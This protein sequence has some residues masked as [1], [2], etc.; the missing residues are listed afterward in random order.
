MLLMSRIVT[1]LRSRRLAVWLLLACV[2]WAAL[3]SAVPQYALDGKEQVV[4]W[5]ADHPLAAVP[6]GLLGLHAAWTAPVF[7]LA[8][9]VLAASTGACAF[10]RTRWAR[11]A[12]R[13][14]ARLSEARR[15]E[16]REH[17]SVNVDAGDRDVP[18]AL[19]AAETVLR[20][21][22]YRVEDS[23]ADAIAAIK[24]RYGPLG[25]SLFH[26]SLTALFVVVALG[27]L[28]RSEGLIGVPVGGQVPNRADQYGLLERG[29]LYPDR[30]AGLLVA[31]PDMA[32]GQVR[33]GVKIGSVP[34]VQ[35]ISGGAVVADQD[36]YANNPLRYGSLMIHLA[37]EGLVAFVDITAPDGT[38]LPSKRAYFDPDSS[39]PS[40]FAQSRLAYVGPDGRFDVVLEPSPRASE[41]EAPKVEVTVAGPGAASMTTVTILGTQL[42]T[43]VGTLVVRDPGAY[44][45]LSVVDDA[46]VYPIYALFLVGLAGLGLAI[47]KPRHRVW[48]SADSASEGRTRLS[49]V[50]DGGTRDTALLIELEDEL[51]AE[52]GHP[53]NAKE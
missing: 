36:V 24:G 52:L 42:D 7:L 18:G 53:V 12:V 37:G 11:V 49:V 44:A 22:G 43:P 48:V 35:L 25:S 28:T 31:V 40:G 4:A 19:G 20:R 51:R 50:T 38:V 26:W 27:H 17:G 9:T 34:R 23:G 14:G 32:G 10:E 3:G 45:R 41:D 21:S 46:S 47:L 39:R 1:V 2:F 6:A 16:L 33:N 13:A 8:V 15:R 5:R 30:Y 29:P